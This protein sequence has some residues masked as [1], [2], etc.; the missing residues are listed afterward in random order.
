M[1]AQFVARPAI[2][3]LVFVAMALI[4]LVFPH[5]ADHAKGQ[6]WG[7]NL[8]VF[9]LGILLSR[10]M[11]PVGAIGIA[12]YVEYRG[13]GLFSLIDWPGWL[14]IL[15]AIIVFDFLIWV[16]HVVF[17]K[18]GW[19]WRLHRMHHADEALDVTTGL[20]FHPIEIALSLLIKVVA[21]LLLGPAAVAVFLFEVLLN[22]GSMITHANWKLPRRLDHALRFLVVTPG[23]HRVHHALDMGD[24]NSNYGFNLS[25]WDR[26]FGTYRPEPVA[27]DDAIR[28]G[29]EGYM[30]EK[31]RRVGQ[32]LTQPFRSPPD[33]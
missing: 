13:W 10:L 15:L 1:E 14:E 22:A 28:F 11:L 30:N 33:A 8:V 21:I 20:R 17:H 16:Q 27:G 32:L 12:A 29:V 4:E 6:R 31:E 9:V 24:T 3:A 26:V 25:I 5:H 7:S 2:F 18:V 23:M 19:L